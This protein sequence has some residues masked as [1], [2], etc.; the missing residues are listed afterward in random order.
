VQL[1][2][3]AQVV[4]QA[5]QARG[6]DLPALQ[7]QRVLSIRQPPHFFKACV[8]HCNP[9][10]LYLDASLRFRPADGGDQRHGQPL[11]V[12]D[13]P[14]DTR[15]L[16]VQRAHSSGAHGIASGWCTFYDVII[17]GD[18]SCRRSFG[19][20]S[21]SGSK[22]GGRTWR[23]AQQVGNWKLNTGS[24]K[25]RRVRGTPKELRP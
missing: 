19:A 18:C 16:G 11:F 9:G 4:Q 6:V 3:D 20:R 14:R 13:L 8:D 2:H 24:K 10:A 1:L 21:K 17:H 5:P 23:R 25:C 15:K 7:P 12:V 22:A